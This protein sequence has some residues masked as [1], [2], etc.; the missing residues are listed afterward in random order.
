MRNFWHRFLM[1]FTALSL[2]LTVATAA[3]WIGVK[4]GFD[5]VVWRSRSAVYS[6]FMDRGN[7]GVSIANEA[8]LRTPSTLPAFRIPIAAAIVLMAILP[9]VMIRWWLSCGAPNGLH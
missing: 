6:V 9:G 2:L 8:S 4:P 1:A 3:L 5:K 7:I